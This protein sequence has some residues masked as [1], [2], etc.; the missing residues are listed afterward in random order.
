LEG[1]KLK[2]KDLN[3]KASFQAFVESHFSVRDY[4]I[5]IGKH[6]QSW[7]GSVCKFT[8]TFDCVCKPVKMAGDIW[9]SLSVRDPLLPDPEPAGNSWLQ[10]GELVALGV[11]SEK[12][13]PSI[14]SKPTSKITDRKKVLKSETVRSFIR[15]CG[16]D[17]GKLRCVYSLGALDNDAQ[18]QLL[19]EF[20]DLKYYCGS[21]LLPM[22]HAL[23]TRSKPVVVDDQLSCVAPMELQYYHEMRPKALLPAR[24]GWPVVCYHC[25]SQDGA[26]VDQGLLDSDKYAMVLPICPSCREQGKKVK[27]TDPSKAGSKK[28]SAPSGSKRNADEAKLTQ[29]QWAADKRPVPERDAGEDVVIAVVGKQNQGNKKFVRWGKK[30]GTLY[31]ADM[32]TWQ[33][34][35]A[36]VHKDDVEGKRARFKF[37]Q[38]IFTGTIQP[39]AKSDGEARGSRYWVKFHSARHKD[40]YVDLELPKTVREGEYSWW[41]LDGYGTNDEGESDEEGED[42]SDE[43]G[44]DSDGTENDPDVMETTGN[45]QAD[46][47]NHAVEQND[48]DIGEG[49]CTFGSPCLC[50]SHLPPS[51]CSSPSGASAPLSQLPLL[52]PLSCLCSSLSLSLSCLCSSLSQLPLLLSAASARLSQLPR[53]LSLSCPYSS[54]CL[55]SS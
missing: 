18:M 13:R 2:S 33:S 16:D 34:I 10:Y 40:R 25:G 23:S 37:K 28:C 41:R 53:L 54:Q 17:C 21:Q 36:P 4:F 9:Q 12:Y 26:V 55:Y 35:D 8:H 22:E 29:A 27:T 5:V 1:L 6:C 7:D 42:S 51:I 44:E 46:D 19:D 31:G 30:D 39:Q 15:C 3:G 49:A 52:L 14:K 48:N 24:A 11:T 45:E 38:T 20:Q 32:C 47:H 50:S 43:E